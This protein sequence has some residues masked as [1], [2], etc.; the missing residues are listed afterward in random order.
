M[1]EIRLFK[2]GLAVDDR[3]E[4]GFIND[5]N[6]DRVKRF[7]WVT[8]HK[9]GFV[10]AWHAHRREEKYIT[11]AQGV[12]LIG[13]VKID[14]WEKPSKNAKVRRYVLSADQP[15][16]LHV[17]AGYA[18]GFMSLTKDAKIIFYSTAT[19]EESQGDDFRYDAYYWDPWKIVER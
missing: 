14:D 12:A 19:L 4:V 3:G 16:I 9:S 15:S 5:F 6:F 8:N 17:P 7:Y 18:N 10:R 2:G 13:V 1:D 11:V